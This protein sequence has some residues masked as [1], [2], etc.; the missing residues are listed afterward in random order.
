MASRGAKD[1]AGSSEV[2]QLLKKYCNKRSK[3]VVSEQ[4][5][6]CSVKRVSS[7]EPST[8]DVVHNRMFRCSEMSAQA[9]MDD[10]VQRLVELIKAQGDY[11]DKKIKDSIDLQDLNYNMFKKLTSSVQ[12]L[13]IQTDQAEASEVQ[14][15]RQKIA[16]AF[17]VTS[18]L[19]SLNIVHQ[20]RLLSFGAQ[21]IEESHSAWVEQHGGW[22]EAFS[23]D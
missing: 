19:S 15:Q 2:F 1:D 13:V 20:R 12:N 14:I 5:M 3:Q 4:F 9:N 17:E 22:A 10:I 21:Y 23:V 7:A 11:I 6:L 16:L 8:Y 18:R